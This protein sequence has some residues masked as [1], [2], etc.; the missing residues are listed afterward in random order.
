[1]DTQCHLVAVL[2][3]VTSMAACLYCFSKPRRVFCSVCDPLPQ[4]LSEYDESVQ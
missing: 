3:S 2:Y 1:M 4:E